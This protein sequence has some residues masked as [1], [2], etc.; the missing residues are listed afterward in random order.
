MN[1]LQDAETEALKKKLYEHL[2]E[3][4]DQLAKD[5]GMTRS[6]LLEYS[7]DAILEKCGAEQAKRLAQIWKDCEDMR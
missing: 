6:Q 1:G 4:I 3:A 7:R 5:Y 2:N